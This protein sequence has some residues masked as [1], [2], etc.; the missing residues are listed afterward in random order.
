MNAQKQVEAATKKFVDQVTRKI[1]KLAK[2]EFGA[3]NGKK[4]LLGAK[5]T[6][7]EMRCRHVSKDGKKC[8]RRSK[9]PRFHYFC[10]NH[11]KRTVKP[12][13][14]K[15]VAK[16]KPVKKTVK[17]KAIKVVTAPPKTDNK[18]TEA[19]AQ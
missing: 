10:E 13:P 14:V 16:P 11:L 12:K 6:D 1:I 2:A 7:Q 8:R 3:K 15:K 4:V 17:P 18:P 5:R 9:G 19:A